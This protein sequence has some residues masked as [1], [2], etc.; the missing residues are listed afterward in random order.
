MSPGG[1]CATEACMWFNNFT[2]I[3][4]EPTL[5][6]D[7]RTFQ[8]MNING[9]M[10]DWTKVRINPY[11]NIQLLANLVIVRPIH[12]APL[13]V[14]PSSAP[15][16]LEVV[17]LMDVLQEKVRQVTIVQVVVMLMVLQLKMLS[18]R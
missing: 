3:S 8:D 1:Q 11:R 17:I 5:P 6:D 16:V 4:G 18:F 10:Y 14:L 15:V 12:G 9:F 7:M 2:F 13:V